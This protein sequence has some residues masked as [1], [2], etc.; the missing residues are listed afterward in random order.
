M[1]LQDGKFE[2]A[3]KSRIFTIPVKRGMCEPSVVKLENSGYAMTIRAEDRHMYCTTSKDGINWS[4]P[5]PWRWQENNQPIITDSTQQ[6]WLK[7]G[8]KVFL[9]Y[10]RFD[11]SNGDCMRFRGPLY[12]AQA[13]PAK[14]KLIHSSEVVVFPRGKQEDV[15]GLLGNFHCT[16]INEKSAL[17]SDALLF[18]KNMGKGK[19]RKFSTIVKAAQIN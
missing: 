12:M 1:I 11:G 14:G 8:N 10:T 15:E 18:R 19:P 13:D 6:H 16:Q 4:E 5:V 17:V 2:F 7:L 9:V 3:G